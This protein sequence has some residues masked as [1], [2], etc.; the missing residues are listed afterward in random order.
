MCEYENLL[1]ISEQAKIDSYN[2]VFWSGQVK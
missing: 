2:D 1:L